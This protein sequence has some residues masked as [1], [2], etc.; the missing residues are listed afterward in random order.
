MYAKSH[1]S[2]R[3][4]WQ[5]ALGL[6]IAVLS[7]VAAACGG[8]S[9]DDAS[10]PNIVEAG[11]VR[12]QLPDDVELNTGDE[13]PAEEVGEVDASPGESASG[14]EPD[15]APDAAGAAAADAEPEEPEEDP[16]AIPLAEDDTPPI[17]GLLEAFQVFSSC[18]GDEGLEFVGAP[19]QNGATAEDFDPS[20]LQALQR[21]AAESGIVQAIAASQAAD[22]ALT[23]EEIEDRNEAFL[24]FVPCLE[25][26]G[27]TVAEIVPDERGLLQA[28]Q[29]NGGLTPPPGVEFFDSND[30]GECVQEAAQ[31]IDDDS[32]E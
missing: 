24:V 6:I 28:G 16:D 26:R 31:T 19:G 25:L 17:V 7:L 29:N 11:E 2:P 9:S 1:G 8:S 20:Y 22:A 3:A 13:D 30:I 23:A 15:D 14:D 32:S 12:V 21:C 27:W 5:L 18:L 4:G 10:G